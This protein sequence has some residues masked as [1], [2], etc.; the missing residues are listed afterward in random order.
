MP[1]ENYQVTSV[2]GTVHDLQIRNYKYNKVQQHITALTA[3][4]N[5]GTRTM[6]QFLK[7]VSYDAPEPVNF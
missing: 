4:Y 7:A 1:T 6:E 3:E 2:R 5:G